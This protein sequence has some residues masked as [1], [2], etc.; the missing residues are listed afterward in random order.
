MR[1]VLMMALAVGGCVVGE[2]PNLSVEVDA[3]VGVDL[4]ADVEVELDDCD[5]TSF[6][7]LSGRCDGEHVV[8]DAEGAGCVASREG[9]AASRECQLYGVCGFEL[10]V[11]RATTAGC[12]ASAAC[13]MEGRCR[14]SF[15]A[16]R[17]GECVE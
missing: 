3:D 13:Q 7:A 16:S 14:A 12:R 8:G 15:A 5:G 6:C 9:C 17:A 4:G 2:N 11:C 10:G 1:V